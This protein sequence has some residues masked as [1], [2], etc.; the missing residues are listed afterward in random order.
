MPDRLA[1]RIAIH[2][3]GQDQ[4]DIARRFA[5]SGL[6]GAEQLDGVS[7]VPGPDGVPLLPDTPAILAGRRDEVITSGD[8]VIILLDV[9]QVHLKPTDVPGAVVLPGPVR[10]AVPTGDRVSRRPQREPRPAAH[11]AAS[12]GGPGRRP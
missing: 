12:R 9:D 4:Q 7:W 1:D 6:S 11:R 5:T 10:R 3:L 8:H 2:I